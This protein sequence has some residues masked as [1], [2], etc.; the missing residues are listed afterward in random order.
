M[1]TPSGNPSGEGGGNGGLDQPGR[2]PRG[3][4]QPN[5]DG[6]AGGTGEEVAPGDPANLEF[7]KQAAELVLQRLKD[8]LDRGEV[9]PQLLEELGWT[10]DEMQRFVS[11]MS[12]SL[13]DEADAESPE[14]LA[15]RVQFEEMLRSLNLDRTGA[16]R[17]AGKQPSREVDQIE[18]RR[19]PVPEA[20]RKAWERYTQQMSKQPA[21]PA[22]KP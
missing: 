12:K 16:K 1:G 7:K 18:A 14:A 11:R 3:G 22:K 21:S 4:Q 19:A 17:A 15:R 5:Q 8:G 10:P 2:Y 9:D 13:H 6:T 20:Y